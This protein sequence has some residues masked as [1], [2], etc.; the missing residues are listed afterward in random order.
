MIAIDRATYDDLD[1]LV[2][3]V[4]SYRVFYGQESDAP[5]ERELVARHLRNGTSTI[6]LARDEAGEPLGFVQ[7][8]QT[9]STVRLGP[10]LILED[11]FVVPHA[12][13]AGAAT[14]LLERA[15]EYAREIGATGM[16]LETA[17]DNA[18]AQRVYEGAGWTRE[19]A[20]CK[21][22]APL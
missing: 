4:A 14:K 7:L 17:M 22:N 18:I 1:A 16:F 13:R 19:A 6:Y 21:Y 2:P 9:C 15:I 11:L 12:R 8:F 20:F 3:M 10:S 5:R